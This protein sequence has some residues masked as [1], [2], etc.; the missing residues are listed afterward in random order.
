MI[1]SCFISRRSYFFHFVNS[2][3]VVVAA[4]KNNNN[5]GADQGK[6]KM[7]VQM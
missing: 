3:G 7:E 6:I 2:Q 1:S 5:D 4:D